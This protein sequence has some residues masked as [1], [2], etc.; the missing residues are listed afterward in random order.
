MSPQGL[1]TTAVVLG[2]FVLSGGASAV[3][4]GVAL[5]RANRQLAT[6]ALGCYALQCVVLAYVVALS[7]LAGPW[8]VLLV[9]SGL[10]YYFIPR[11]TWRYLQ[12]LHSAGEG[13]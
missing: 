9:A 4:Y 2:F 12:N 6:V 11:V 7:P 3:F 1:L 13:H 8:K 5:L 10:A